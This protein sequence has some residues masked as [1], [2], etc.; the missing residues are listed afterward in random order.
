LANQKLDVSRRAKSDVAIRL[1][2]KTWP[3]EG[4]RSD[5]VASECTRKLCK[6]IQ[7]RLIFRALLDDVEAKGF[8]NVVGDEIGGHARQ[9]VSGKRRKP[10]RDRQLREARPIDPTLQK[11]ANRRSF[12]VGDGQACASREERERCV[13]RLI[14]GVHGAWLRP[15]FGP[16]LNDHPPNEG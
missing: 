1:N 3:F 8:E 16:C 15:R 11:F 6:G 7:Q 4:D 12:G 14:A 5:T 9:A 13:R 2:G 10:E